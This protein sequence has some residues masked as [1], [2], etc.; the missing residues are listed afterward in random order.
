MSLSQLQQQF[1]VAVSQ[2]IQFAHEQGIGLTFGDAYRDPRLHGQWG[3]KESYSAAHSVH[4]M[5]LAVDFNV[6]VDGEYISDGSHPAYEKLGK[7]WKSLH[8]LARWGGDFKSKDAG[9]FSFEYS[10]YK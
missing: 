10:G 2:L 5:R 4:K 6:F 8:P 3:Q 1:T 7:K 9:H